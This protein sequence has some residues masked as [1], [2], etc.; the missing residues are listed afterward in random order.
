MRFQAGRCG[1]TAAGLR[2]Q[3]MKPSKTIKKL[4]LDINTVR[5]LTPTQIAT[6]SGG[7][8]RMLSFGNSACPTS[9]C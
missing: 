8:A 5:D 2:L 9:T 4:P 7:R 3:A 6:V 1:H